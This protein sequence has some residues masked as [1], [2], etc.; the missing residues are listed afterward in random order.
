MYFK[1]IS[2]KTEDVLGNN[3][4]RPI[5]SFLERESGLIEFWWWFIIII[6]IINHNS[7]I[8][9]EFELPEKKKVQ[10]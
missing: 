7:M 9:S 6:I 5:L 1:L 10:I 2:Y 3:E 8:K 4:T